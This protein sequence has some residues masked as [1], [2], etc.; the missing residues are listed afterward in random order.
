MNSLVPEGCFFPEEAGFLTVELP[1][2]LLDAP[3]AL[4][5]A[6]LL[7]EAERVPDLERGVFAAVCFFFSAM[8]SLS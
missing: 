6:V 8:F 5:P 7:P 3:A 1:V 2:R 4:F